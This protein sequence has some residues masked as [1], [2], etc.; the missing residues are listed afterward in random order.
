MVVEPDERVWDALELNKHLN[1]CKFNIVK[2]FIS[3]KKL[4][5]TGRGYDTCCFESCATKIPSYT[6]DEIKKKYDIQDFNV[7]V[8]DCEG[9]LEVFF[10]EN[11]TFCNNLRLIIF[12]A[13]CGGKCNYKKIRTMLVDQN[14]KELKGGFQNVWIKM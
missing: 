1:M 14:F 9:F 8:A 12:E 6:L 3:N 7:L 4:A 5:L 2:G 10:D 11:P 13:D